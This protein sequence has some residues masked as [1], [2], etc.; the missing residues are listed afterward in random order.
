M[1]VM[2]AAVA[3]HELCRRYASPSGSLSVSVW[4][5]K[6]NPYLKVYIDSRF[7]YLAGALPQK[8]EGFDVVVTEM[9]DITM[10]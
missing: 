7:L 10:N 4:Y 5:D 6:P 3:A 1:T 8:F 9:P 2:E